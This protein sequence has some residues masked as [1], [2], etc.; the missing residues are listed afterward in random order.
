MSAFLE[1]LPDIIK[2]VGLVG[3]GLWAVWT[4]HKLQ[5]VRAAELMTNERLTTRQTSRIQQE[6][7]RTR[8]LSQQPQLAIKLNVTEAAS[9]TETCKSFLCVT[10]ILKNEGEQNLQVAFD[11]S[12]LSI[13]RMVFKNGD[14]TI[15]V[16]RFGPSY[17]SSDSYQPQSFRERRLRVGQKRQMVLTVLPV[18]EPG[19]YIVQ[20]HAMYY[21]VPFDGEKPS[22]EGTVYIDA[23]EQT[24]CY[25]TGN[26]M[27][28]QA[29]SNAACSRIRYPELCKSAGACR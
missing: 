21:K 9:L 15:D 7:L 11:P 29:M 14:Q 26:P 6:E 19:V 10:V 27:R 18:A 5:K 3:G 17:F 28:F 25:A 8:L 2:A 22:P 16:H 20:F 23:Y 13:G 12:A 24:V 1:Q 4:F